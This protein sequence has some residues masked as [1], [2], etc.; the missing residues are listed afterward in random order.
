[1]SVFYVEVMFNKYESGFL[2]VFSTHENAVAACQEK[3]Q[4][5]YEQTEP[6]DW[7]PRGDCVVAQGAI[8]YEFCI[9]Q[10][11]VDTRVVW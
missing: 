10:I 1:M 3:A 4:E 6:L 7:K 2:G 9:M 11:E 5:D 8:G